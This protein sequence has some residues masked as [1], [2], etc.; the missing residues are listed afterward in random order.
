MLYEQSEPPKFLRTG[1]PPGS[2]TWLKPAILRDRIVACAV[3]LASACS[4]AA[5]R[6]THCRT[7]RAWRPQVSNLE[8]SLYVSWPKHPLVDLVNSLS[9]SSVSYFSPLVIMDSA[10]A[11]GTEEAVELVKIESPCVTL[12]PTGVPFVQA[13]PFAISLVFHAAV[14]HVICVPQ[15]I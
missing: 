13:T 12:W 3:E 9:H 4:P 6:S 14:P 2:P 5:R 8:K 11:G 1:T 10:C 15:V 7:L